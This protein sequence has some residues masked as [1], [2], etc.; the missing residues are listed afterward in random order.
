MRNRRTAIILVLTVAMVLTGCAESA[1]SSSQ[2]IET[3]A[4]IEGLVEEVNFYIGQNNSE[5][6]YGSNFVEPLIIDD[7]GKVK[8]EGKHI[9]YTF[10]FEVDEDGSVKEWKVE[11]FGEDG[12]YK[13]SNMNTIYGYM[14][15][16]NAF[17]TA[18]AGNEANDVRADFQNWAESTNQSGNIE[19]ENGSF[20]YYNSGGKDFL[21]GYGADK[22]IL[23]TSG[24][25]SQ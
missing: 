16:S 11:Y 10:R 12:I 17:I 4:T 15:Y 23:T 25:I 7:D 24:Q 19:T 13:S 8:T 5:D 9:D 3:K 6:K 18:T 22:Y 2:D 20:S 1:T 21:R 14:F